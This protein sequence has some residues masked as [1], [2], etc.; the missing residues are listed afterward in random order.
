MTGK[1]TISRVET[2]LLEGGKMRRP[3]SRERISVSAYLEQQRPGVEYTV[4]E[5]V[6]AII[7]DSLG[8]IPVWQK[9]KFT[10]ASSKAAKAYSPA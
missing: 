7:S 4:Y 1:S 10:I 6:T 9:V 3:T 5:R 8:A 2:W